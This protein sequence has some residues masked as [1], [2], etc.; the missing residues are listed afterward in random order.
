MKFSEVVEALM[1]GKRIR[2]TSWDSHHAYVIYEKEYNTLDFYMM[3]DGEVYNLQSSSLQEV[4]LVTE[5]AISSARV[6]EVAASETPENSE[7]T[8]EET[9]TRRIS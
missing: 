6:A 3:S 8:A 1:M 4:S 9:T 5:P 7:A 2:K